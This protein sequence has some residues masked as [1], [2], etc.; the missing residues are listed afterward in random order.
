MAELQQDSAVFLESTVSKLPRI[1]VFLAFCLLSSVQPL[2][3]QPAPIESE[4]H[5]TETS[6]FDGTVFYCTECMTEVPEQIGAGDKCPH[7]G[8]FFKSATNAD[9]SESKAEQASDG[10][11]LR[12]WSG[13]ALVLLFATE[14]GVRRWRNSR[15][16]SS[17]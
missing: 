15:T 5:E 16:A 14:Y 12:V 10:I 6:P 1:L 13:I 2:R 4:D 8:A 3:G 9:G 7:C 11:S 17:S